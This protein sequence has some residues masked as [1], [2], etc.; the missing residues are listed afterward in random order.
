M[1]KSSDFGED[2]FRQLSKMYN[3]SDMAN[4]A[5][6]QAQSDKAALYADPPVPIATR[7]QQAKSAQTEFKSL[8]ETE[9][10]RVT[11]VAM[12]ENERLTKLRQSEETEKCC[13]LCLEVVPPIYKYDELPIAMPCCGAYTCKQC[14]ND[15]AR[16]IIQARDV[17]AKCFACRR[18]M[19]KI[20]DQMQNL[21]GG[22]YGKALAM[23]TLA[24]QCSE[25]NQTSKALN[26]MHRAAELGSCRAQSILCLSYYKGK[27]RGMAV[28]K[29]WSKA[30]DLAQR[31]ANQGYSMG[32]SSLGY[33][34]EHEKQSKDTL[35]PEA[36]RLFSVS[37]YQECPL[38][39]SYLANW[40]FDQY[41]HCNGI[42]FKS[43]EDQVKE[44]TSLL[45]SLYWYGKST[46]RELIE[47][48]ST[49]SLMMMSKLLELAMGLW[50][51]PS[52]HLM[53]DPITGYSQVPLTVWARRK[54]LRV[55]A[56]ARDTWG[57]SP[58]MCNPWKFVCANC[59]RRD[60]QEKLKACAQCKTF[61]YCSK[62][63]QVKHW[64]AGHKLECKGHWVEQ[65]FPK[66][67]TPEQVDG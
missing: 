57:K 23:I 50:H 21:K 19:T 39:M 52:K 29:S 54:A 55:D 15:F 45:L 63:C 58:L 48:Q 13:S 9:L 5:L 8:V 30:M 62:E 51:N 34:T 33:F 27:Y 18:P 17:N 6:D 16:S 37:A 11:R 66:I 2:L 59:G 26:Y 47:G 31:A 67:R 64:K 53:C 40:Y 25:K 61:S 28:E 32:I 22:A 7:A 4:K 65:F 42:R 44:R 20:K 41:A 35:N 24:D 43:V 60:V 36:F 56:K 49:K 12:D 3:E 46:E 14:M 10:K 1:A 38:G